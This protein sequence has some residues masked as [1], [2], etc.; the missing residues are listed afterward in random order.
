M[1]LT[2]KPIWNIIR[3][4]DY[5]RIPAWIAKFIG[6]N[7]DLLTKGA[8]AIGVG[9]IAKK[10]DIPLVGENNSIGIDFAELRYRDDP[11]G[12]AI[13]AIYKNALRTSWGDDKIRGIDTIKKLVLDSENITDETSSYAINCIQKI[14][15]SSRWSDIKGKANEAIAAIGKRG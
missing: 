2:L 9:A 5:S 4:Y 1:H 14:A 12:A 10:Y 15:D 11:K 8:C 7:G 3:T 13:N 6:N